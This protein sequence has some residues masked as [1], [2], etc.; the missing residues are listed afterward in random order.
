MKYANFIRRENVRHWYQIE[1]KNQKSESKL[2]YSNPRERRV[3]SMKNKSVSCSAFGKGRQSLV[4]Q[5][6]RI[7]CAIRLALLAL[8]CSLALPSCYVMSDGGIIFDG[9]GLPVIGGVGPVQAGVCDPWGVQGFNQGFG[10]WGGGPVFGGFSRSGHPIYLHGGGPVPDVRFQ[11]PYGQ[12]QYIYNQ[13]PD[14]SGF[15][16]GCQLGFW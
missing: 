16:G 13:N 3:V 6:V 12:L 1:I 4:S 14:R 11:N 5:S 10:G 7:L 2:P 8:V 9:G 15:G